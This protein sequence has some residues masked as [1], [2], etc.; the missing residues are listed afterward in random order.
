[1]KAKRMYENNRRL[2]QP[3]PVE[4]VKERDS[5]FAWNYAYKV[6]ETYLAEGRP[7]KIDEFLRLLRNAKATDS[8]P[9]LYNVRSGILLG[10]RPND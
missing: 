6:R 5:L 9:V 8:V 7:E 1:M 4:V 10:S 2:L 3:E